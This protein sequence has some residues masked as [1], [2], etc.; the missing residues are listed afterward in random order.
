[1]MFSHLSTPVLVFSIYL[2]LFDIAAAFAL[3]SAL[4][5]APH[6]FSASANRVGSPFFS[7]GPGIPPMRARK[8][9]RRGL[10]PALTGGLSVPPVSAL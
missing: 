3:A 2:F 8:L 5:L 4:L 1:M 9:A 6:A 10:S 7:I